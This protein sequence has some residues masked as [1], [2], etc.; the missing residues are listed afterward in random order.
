MGIEKAAYE[1][2]Q[3]ENAILELSLVDAEDGSPVDLTSETLTQLTAN[4]KGADGSVLPVYLDNPEG[5]STDEITLSGAG[6]LGK[7]LVPLSPAQ[8]DLLKAGAF[9]DFEVVRVDDGFT[10]VHRFPRKL[11]VHDRVGD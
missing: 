1:L 3:G 9:Q 7:I 5:V 6:Q 10:T 11:T 2:S 8:T 4:F